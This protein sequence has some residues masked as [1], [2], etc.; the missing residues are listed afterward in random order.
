MRSIRLQLRVSAGLS[1]ASPL[2]PTI[3]GLGTLLVD[4][5]NFMRELTDCQGIKGLV[6]FMLR[7]I[8]LSMDESPL[9]NINLDKAINDMVFSE[10]RHMLHLR[11]NSLWNQVLEW[12]FWKQAT[13]FSHMVST[14]DQSIGEYGLY[15]GARR[16]LQGFFPAITTHNQQELP[17][18]GPLLIVSNHPGAADILALAAALP[19]KDIKFVAQ[20]R[21]LLRA[22]NNVSEH[23]LYL[24]S[25]N[26]GRGHSIIEMIDYLKEGGALLLFPRGN[27]EPDPAV[28][29][30]ARTYLT[31]WSKSIGHFLS[32]VPDIRLAPVFVSGVI[33]KQVA[34]SVLAELGKNW[35][36]RIHM[37]SILSLVGQFSAFKNWLVSPDV[38]VGEAWKASQ[39]VPSLQPELLTS[40]AITS[41]N[42]LMESNGVVY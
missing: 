39:M 32:R 10:L 33:S 4:G 9:Q 13:R 19:R 11:T 6:V 41:V 26:M 25:P 35:R 3:R 22:V 42:D 40:T 38:Y 29:T 2:S 23:I 27:W 28:M 37:M 24:D 21:P 34:H 15:E 1:P 20:D 30:G 18:E 16:G 12:S 7:D 8:I 17:L 36:Y 14:L 5:W 31:Q